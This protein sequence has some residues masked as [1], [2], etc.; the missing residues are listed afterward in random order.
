MFSH[1]LLHA[2]MNHS[3]PA[4]TASPA[5]DPA[6]HAAACLAVNRLLAALGIGRAPFDLPN[7]PSGDEARLAACWRA[8]GLPAECTGGGT[9]GT[10][11]DVTGLVIAAEGDEGKRISG[12]LAAGLA[13]A[14]TGAVEAAGGI[15][16][17]AAGR[18]G[19]QPWDVAMGWFT[20]SFPLMGGL[21]AGFAVVAD[22]D[23]CRREKIS[24]AAVGPAVAEIYVNPLAGL[25]RS[26]WVFVLGHEML[27]AG[28]RHGARALGRDP[29]LWN[30]AADYVVN[31]WLAE[32]GI[33]EM[34]NGALHDPALRG[35]SAEAVYER[36]ATDARRFRKLATL[37]GVPVGD[38]LGE[39]LPH[40]G[41]QLGGIGLDEFYRRA[42]TTGLAYHQASGRGLLPSGL[43]EEIR[44]LDQ[45][46]ISW[47]VALA[48][49]FETH[50]RSPEPRRS[51]ARPSRRQA[52][53]P[54]IIRPGRF[55]PES[56]ELECTFGVVLDTSGSMPR[57]LLGKALGAIAA[58]AGAKDVPAAR[59]VFCDA[60]WYDAGYLP[61][62]QIAGRVRIRGRG[63][64]VL[65]PAVRFLEKAP[66][67][68]A[69]GPILIITDGACDRLRVARQHAYLIPAGASLPF[70]PAGPVFR[71]A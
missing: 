66:D 54:G 37:R 50:V 16:Q 10:L 45:P 47:D 55:F 19:K 39:S 18:P 24:I 21:A 14:V 58:Y 28:L 70:A 44:V 41:E 7:D 32:L 62:D 63:G 33:G 69:D 13:R 2:G 31:G 42:L 25:T 38:I 49:W 52:A 12:L 11:P 3:D 68:P 20:S 9:A 46:P 48:R 4:T 27:H 15:V 6:H 36:I 65:Q 26:E 59:V 5:R 29:Y 53:S 17:D 23:L 51:Y 1:L 56:A 40:A 43:V 60:T 30:V 67:F 61:V 64:T 57:Q 8:D 22:A 71:V 35:L 34:P